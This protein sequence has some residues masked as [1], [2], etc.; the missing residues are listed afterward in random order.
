MEITRGYLDSPNNP[1]YHYIHFFIASASIIIV[2]PLSTPC[3][4]LSQETN[5]MKAEYM[6]LL[7]IVAVAFVAMYLMANYGGST[8]TMFGLTPVA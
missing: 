8:A 2:F 1:F 6:R 3:G 7:T 4:I 5:K